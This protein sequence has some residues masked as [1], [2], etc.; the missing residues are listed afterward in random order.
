MTRRTTSYKL[1]E[2][3][4]TVVEQAR[5]MK[6]WK[7]STWADRAEISESTLK[8]FLNGQPIRMEKFISICQVIGLE[9][10]QNL[11]AWEDNDSTRVFLEDLSQNPPAPPEA[12]LSKYALVA[13]GTFT[14]SQKAQIELLLKALGNLL[15]EGQ[16]HIAP[17]S[18]DETK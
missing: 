1:S 12:T 11:I 14:D 10:W 5:V 9:D 15:S 8:R 16:I 7:R 6:G 18:P 13:T 2:E 4:I 3:C 17:T